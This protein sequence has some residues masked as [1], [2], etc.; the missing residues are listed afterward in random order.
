MGQAFYGV[1]LNYR[2]GIRTQKPKECLLYFPGIKSSGE[3][4]RL[5]GRKVMWRRE[6]CKVVGKIISLHGR[7]GVVRARFRKGVPGQALGDR[8]YIIG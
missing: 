7:K 1:I 5:I 8:V 2:L 4:G 6:G 3:A